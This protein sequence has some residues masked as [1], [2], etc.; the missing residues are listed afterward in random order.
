M[1]AGL[2]PAPRSEALARRAAG[3]ALVVVLHAA[4]ILALLNALT[5]PRKAARVEPGEEQFILLSPPKAST[6]PSRNASVS[7]RARPAAAVPNYGTI[8][9]PPLEGKGNENALGTELFDC[10]LEN[11]SALDPKE[12]QACDDRLA[13]NRKPAPDIADH[14]G[15]IRLASLW[16]RQLARKKAPLL[17]PCFGASGQSKMAIRGLWLDVP[18]VVRGLREGIDLDAQP[19]YAPTH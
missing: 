8:T 7:P 2:F 19:I 4:L 11:L 18:C 5:S 10:S 3:A 6:P 13:L 17:L 12:R 9:L 14:S 1:G 16:A 15:E